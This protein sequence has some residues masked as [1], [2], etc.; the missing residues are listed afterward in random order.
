MTIASD[1]EMAGTLSAGHVPRPQMPGSSP[2]WRPSFSLVELMVVVAIL[3]L[4][5]ALL[6]PSYVRS[7]RR[8]QYARYLSDIKPM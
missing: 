8:A 1:N 4:L 3:S 7:L 5:V 2:R 6:V